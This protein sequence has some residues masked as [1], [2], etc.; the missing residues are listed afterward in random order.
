M[1]FE[2][3]I[4]DDRYPEYKEETAVLQ[5]LGARLTF[6]KSADPAALLHAGRNADA[7]I[8]NLAPMPGI[9]I[10]GLAR[11]RVISRY[12]V[13]YD[14]VDIAAA[15]AR[16]IWVANVPDYCGED[17]SDQAFALWMS[18]VRNVARRDR[19]VRAGVWDMTRGAPQGRV[20]GKTFVF[21]GFGQIARILRRKI[22]G[23]DLGR[24]LVYD[25]FL[26]EAA[27]KAAGAE[28]V[29]WE[30]ALQ[31]GDYFSIHMPLNDQTR[32]MFNAAAFR[33]MKNTAIL[34]NTSRGPIVDEADLYDALTQGV[35]H[36]AGLDVF[37]Q[38][39]INPDN[40][41]LKLDN[42]TLSGH[43]GWYTEESQTELKRKAAENVRDALTGNRPK[44][45]VNKPN[46]VRR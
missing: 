19:D 42:V 33:M 18:C 37:A 27:I 12:G 10:N 2:V 8:V 13:G 39:P 23:F 7:I 24:I 4:A 41:L 25:P 45:A 28:K 38:E 44:Y 29:N 32:G 34:V 15:T 35:I 31:E 36:A 9:V 43:T 3:L 30:T 6:V 46:V 40:P 22:S 5:P 16:G 21:C 26:D 20:K 14:N 11:C 1:S 17:V